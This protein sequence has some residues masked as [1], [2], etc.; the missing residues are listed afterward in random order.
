RVPAVVFGVLCIPML[1]LLADRVTSRVEAWMASLLL[2]VSYHHIWFS[3]NAR[4]YTGLLFFA[5]LTTWLFLIGLSARTPQEESGE[6]HAARP[7]PA[8]GT[9]WLAYA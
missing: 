1:F 2:T 6:I 7:S 9:L 5:M 4:A 8:A 3:Q